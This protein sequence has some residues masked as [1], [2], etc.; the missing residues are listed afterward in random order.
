MIERRIYGVRVVFW[1]V[2]LA[3]IAAMMAADAAIEQLYAFGEDW[4]LVAVQELC[5]IGAI[6]AAMWLER[7][8][9]RGSRMLSGWLSPKMAALVAMM[10]YM[11]LMLVAGGCTYG[12][13]IEGASIAMR[14]SAFT[15]LTSLAV[16]V[17]TSFCTDYYE[18]TREQ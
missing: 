7:V 4:S 18:I 15:A 13:A 17:A 8:T 16:I 9:Y 2:F 12:P 11:M 6:F 10:V 1:A 3:M 5:L 14:C